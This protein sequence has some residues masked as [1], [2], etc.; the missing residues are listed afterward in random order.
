MEG[1]AA[2]LAL[3]P[4]LITV[5]LAVGTRR[6]HLSLGLGLGLSALLATGFQPMPAA[7]LA[8]A[9]V[10]QPI[11]VVDHVLLLGF[12]L[13]V[14]GMTSIVEANGG[15]RACV[16]LVERVVRGRRSCMGATWLA[17]LF[18]FF[19]DYANCLLVGTAFRP[20]YDRHRISRAKL[21][22]LVDTTA[23]P[24]ASVSVLSTWI[25]YELGLLG[26]ALADVPLATGL[27]VFFVSTLPY[28]FYSLYALMFAGVLAFTG[29]DF[30]P[31]SRVERTTYAAAGVNDL[32]P[33]SQPTRGQESAWLAAGPYLS[34]LLGTLVALYWQGLTALSSSGSTAP[35]LRAVIGAANPYQ[36]MACG[37][38]LASGVAL[39]LSFVSRTLSPTA[40]AKAVWLG[41]RQIAGALIVLYLAWGFSNALDT[42]GTAEALVGLLSDKLAAWSLPVLTFLVAAAAAFCT[43]SSFGSM[44]LLIPLVVPLAISLAGGTVDA[45]V[46]ATVGA[47]LAGACFGD[48]SSP[49]SD[50]T[51]LSA[52]ASGTEVITHVQT[53]LPYALT[54]AGVAVFLGYLPTG[55]G[56]DPV[57]LLALGMSLCIGLIFGVGRKGGV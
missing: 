43:G 39:M 48:H 34:L 36:A 22:Y 4:P 27:L 20:F 17:G 46:P 31:M 38:S 9:F 11:L 44:A 8:I 32:S 19:D 56:G 47:I 3:L 33:V 7:E 16:R 42:L 10:A 15:T 23:A 14:A 2:P 57:V 37:A 50:T 18:V 55:L 54:V 28:R 49:I 29:R 40:A 12:S 41:M 30:G 26:D 45:P 35:T 25:G 53:Q 6:I 52:A 51:I 21:A 1:Q 5:G 24:L 13:L